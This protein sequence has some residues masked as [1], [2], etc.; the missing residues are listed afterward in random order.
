MNQYP[1]AQSHH[2]DEIDLKEVFRTILRYKIS[3]ALIS[4]LLLVSS[5]I[6]AYYKPNVYATNAS[7]EILADES[8][9][10]KT[11][12]MMQALGGATINVENEMAVMQSRFILDKALLSLNLTTNYYTKNVLNKSYE[13]YKDSPFFVKT[14]I[15]E[16]V[17]Y[18][19]TF[20]LI[21]QDEESFKLVLE[22][23]VSA[24]SIKGIFSRLGLISLEPK[25]KITYDSIHKYG[26]KISTTWFT[27]TIEKIQELSNDQYSFNFVP[28]SALYDIYGGGLSIAQASEYASVLQLTFQDTVALRAQEILNA[29]AKSYMNEGIE[30][31]TQVAELTLGFIDSQLDSINT[32]LKSS[33]SSLEKYKSNNDVVNITGQA[34]LATSRIADYEAQLLELQTEIDI[35]NNLKH[36]INKNENLSGMTVGMIN[37]A[38]TTLSSLVNKLQ[39]LTQTRNDMLID[40]TE[41][42]PEVQKITKNILSMRRMIKSALKSSLGQ[43]YQRKASLK[44][45]IKKYNSSLTNLPTK[46]KELTRLS[47]LFN[48]NEKIYEYLLQKRAE[49]AIMKSSTI[50]N[51]RVLDAAKLEPIPIKP[52]RKLIVLVGLILGLI[53]GIAYA[54]LREFMVYT[55]TN[56]EEVEKL[57]SLPLY[58]AIPLNKNKTTENIFAEAFRNIR[59]NLQFLPGS[60]KNQIISITSSV[61]NEGK[62]TIVAGLGEILAKSDK[63]VIILDL[64]L[65]K[66][67]LHKNFELSNNIGM[68]NVLTGQNKIKEVIKKTDTDNLDIITTGPLPPNPSEL[69]LTDLFQEMLEKLRVDY[70]YILIDTPPAGLVTDAVIIMN[71]SDISFAVVRSQYTRKEFVKNIDRLAKDHSQN[72]MG[73][74]LNGIQIGAQYGYGYGASYAYGYGNSKYYQNRK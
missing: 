42:H 41:L 45:M 72:R 15:L 2:N 40:F 22:P 1:T 47:R 4:F 57:T 16:D 71:H 6:F 46:E 38:D 31:K 8:R 35:L 60:S 28:E 59:T 61:S 7:I 32:N 13:L 19:K 64:D 10:D 65:R 34:S 70:D 12:F 17:I 26:E 9:V 49:T 11:D 69:I 25:E 55:I 56:A 23:S 66:A 39:T 62:T 20:Q 68:S 48:V 3:I 58:G 36:F 33:E 50:S 18:G 74:I 5:A 73:I 43:L 44:R 29:I 51:A 63:R 14:E 27:F 30:Q 21:P 67:S 53:L 24:L 52:K 37:F 54:F